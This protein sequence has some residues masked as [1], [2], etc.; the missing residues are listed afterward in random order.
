MSVANKNKAECCGC[1]ACAE[2]CPKH[3]ISMVK[4]AKGFLYPKVDVAVCNNC[5][6]CKKC[7]PLEKDNVILNAPLKAFAAWNRN[8][9]E[10]LASSSGGAAHVLSLH[11]LSSGGVVYGC[12]SDDMKIRH[13]RITKQEELYKL[14]G[15]KYVQS[16]VC[17]LYKQVRA[18]LKA[19]I[20][21]LFV[22]TPCQVAG[23]KNYIKDIPGH[24]FLVD[25]ICHGVPSQQMLHEH[26]KYVARGRSAERLS[27]REGQTYRMELQGSSMR[28][29]ATKQWRYVSEPHKDMYYRAFLNGISYRESCYHCKFAQPERVGDITIGDFWG[30]QDDNAMPKQGISVVLPSTDKGISLL[31]AIESKLALKER[32]VEEAIKGNDQLQ[33]PTKP[34][35]ATRPF[36]TLYP[37][38]PF[39]W[40]VFIGLVIRKLRLIAKI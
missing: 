27:F 38:L 1:N 29:G 14:Q 30:L 15:S 26:I 21:V 23:L 13:I 9:D 31:K 18:D 24:L 5:G 33:A 7:C 2:I 11:I 6:L 4:D 20:P 32:D 16:D 12:T 8:H 34:N 17:G 19:S 22:G 10:Y 39:D 36:Q 25:L 35:H 37:M 28:Y 3:C 40:A